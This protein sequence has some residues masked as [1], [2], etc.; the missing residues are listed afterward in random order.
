VGVLK[1]L[2]ACN[3]YR[4]AY[5][6]VKLIVIGVGF[7]DVFKRTPRPYPSDP[8][9]FDAKGQWAAM[10]LS[11]GLTHLKR[12]EDFAQVTNQPIPSLISH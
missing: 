7:F 5:P 11:E 1:S 6:D 8:T 10:Q 9:Q 12:R 2:E 4:K 3:D